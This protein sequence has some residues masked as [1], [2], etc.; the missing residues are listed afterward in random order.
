ML[1]LGQLSLTQ[2]AAK[3]AKRRAERRGWVL[4]QAVVSIKSK[5]GNERVEAIAADLGDLQAV[6]GMAVEMEQRFPQLHSLVCNAGVLLPVK[7]TT[8]DGYEAT[9]GAC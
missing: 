7:A 3:Q 8:S 2:P 9:M 1:Q 4:R 6:R 5:T